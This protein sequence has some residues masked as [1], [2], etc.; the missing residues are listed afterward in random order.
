MIREKMNEIDSKRAGHKNQ[1]ES[2]DKVDELD[3][4]LASLTERDDANKFGGRK[5]II[6]TDS[7]EIRN[8]ISKYFKT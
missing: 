3:K 6:A 5:G 1:P 2:F 8:I 7:G 4:P